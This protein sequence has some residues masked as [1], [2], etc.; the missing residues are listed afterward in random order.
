MP[1]PTFLSIPL[2][3]TGQ[4]EIAD[5][6]QAL[7]RAGLWRKHRLGISAVSFYKMLALSFDKKKIP[8]RFNYSFFRA[9]VLKQSCIWGY[10]QKHKLFIITIVATNFIFKLLNIW[11]LRGLICLFFEVEIFVTILFC[12]PINQNVEPL[13]IKIVALK[14]NLTCLISY[15]Q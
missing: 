9:C 13:V 7:L 5:C 14:Y 1:P 3:C 11:L 8:T 15:Q 6:T 12:C 10:E 4:P 2:E